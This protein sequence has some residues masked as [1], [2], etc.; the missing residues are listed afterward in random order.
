LQ[1]RGPAQHFVDSGRDPVG[2]IESQKRKKAV[3]LLDT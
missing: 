2:R 1:Y 3:F